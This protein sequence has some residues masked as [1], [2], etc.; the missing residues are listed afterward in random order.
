MRV[1]QIEMFVPCMWSVLCVCVRERE[2]VLASEK[3]SEFLTV[4]KCTYVNQTNTDTNR[5]KY[6]PVAT[7][8]AACALDVASAIAAAFFACTS[9]ANCAARACAWIMVTAESR[10]ISAVAIWRCPSRFANL[11]SVYN[12][13]YKYRDK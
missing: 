3:V 1:R 4:R 9:V 5:Y 13:R 8:F 6:K 7:I 10:S 11:F 2:S 12:I